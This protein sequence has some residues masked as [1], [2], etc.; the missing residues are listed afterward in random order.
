[1]LNNSYENKLVEV[2]GRIKELRDIYSLSDVEMAE[3][4]GVS[5]EEYLAYEKGI[6]DP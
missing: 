4:T 5:L 1:M 6:E 3:K 2:A